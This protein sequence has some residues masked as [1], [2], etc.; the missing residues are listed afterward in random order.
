MN[1]PGTFTLAFAAL[2]LPAAALA[3][4]SAGH[5]GGEVM[6]VSGKAERMGKDG[7]AQAV[8]KGMT[9]LEGD[10]IRTAADSHVYVRL[11]DGGLLVVRPASEL[12]VDLWRYDPARPQDSQIKY[13]LDN[14]VARHVSGPVSYTHLTLPTN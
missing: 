6:F 14:G 11:R 1:L 4:S 10:R 3:Q 5:A 8:A 12:H 13:T 9:L 2:A 7:R